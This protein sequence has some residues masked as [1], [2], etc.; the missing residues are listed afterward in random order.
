M[1][2]HQHS[3][4]RHDGRPP[5]GSTINERVIDAME[6]WGD[7]TILS[8]LSSDGS[9]TPVTYLQL[10]TAASQWQAVYRDRNLRAGSTVVVALRHGIDLYAAYLGAVLDGLV[11]AMFAGPSPKQPMDKYTQEVSL[12]IQSSGA[13]LLACDT[14][15]VD[16][17]HQLAHDTL[18]VCTPDQSKDAPNSGIDVQVPFVADADA[19]AFLQYSSGTTG[20]KKGVAI[21]HRALLWQIDQYAQAIN[22]DST[23]VIV[24]WL[25][26]YHDMGLIAC[27]WLPLLTGTPVV[28]MSPFDWVR[29]PEILFQAI[30]RHRGTFCWQPNF[31]YNHLARSI[32]DSEIPK[33]DL[34]SH[35]R[36]H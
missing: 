12:L 27:Y 20:L 26:L 17:F 36:L 15:T 1:A 2:S 31:A 10:V 14:D 35:T 6:R 4:A 34:R 9:T 22:L 8:L 33:L 18:P 32:R 11:P 25:P 24:S 3:L 29:R 30:T 7:R 19:V 5:Q 23:D 16:D 13:A 28:A 21:T